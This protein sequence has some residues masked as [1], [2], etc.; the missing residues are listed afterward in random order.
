[1]RPGACRSG[2][3]LRRLEDQRHVWRA[4]PTRCLPRREPP[5]R[6]P[7]GPLGTA[8]RE[9]AALEAVRTPPGDDPRERRRVPTVSAL[10]VVPG[11]TPCVVDRGTGASYR[12]LTLGGA[13]GF[14]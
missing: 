9:R 7:R 2:R 6:D 10:R 11:G 3:A 1:M 5:H 14:G 13:R 8:Q 12:R 4:Q